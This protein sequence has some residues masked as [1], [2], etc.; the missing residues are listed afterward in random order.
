MSVRAAERRWTWRAALAAVVLGALALRLW[1]LRHGL[2]YVYNADENAHF[3]P[4]AIGF[5]GH[6]L[7]P[8][9]FVN[10]P[11]F[12]YL[13]H[14]LFWARW[15]GEGVQETLAADPGAVFALARGAAA[16]LGAGAVA[17]L[18]L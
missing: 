5:F 3:V 13:L 10:P 18:A 2:P 6:D 12:T 17:L 1:G 16:V 15:G 11:A 8:G 14:V 9:Y 4:R 7:D